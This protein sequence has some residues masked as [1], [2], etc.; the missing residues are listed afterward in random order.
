VLAV[1]HEVSGLTIVINAGLGRNLSLRHFAG[2]EKGSRKPLPI[3]TTSRRVFGARIFL[4][5]HGKNV[6]VM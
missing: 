5:V 3:Q 1:A 6:N 4:V 2:M